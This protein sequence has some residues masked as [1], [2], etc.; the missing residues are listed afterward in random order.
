M[1]LSK[2]L[3]TL[4]L[5]PLTLLTSTATAQR[6]RGV[7]DAYY[8]GIYLLMTESCDDKGI[9]S[10]YGTGEYWCVQ[11]QTQ[12]HFPKYITSD[13]FDSTLQT[14]QRFW[15]VSYFPVQQKHCK[16]R[17]EPACNQRNRQDRQFPDEYNSYQLWGA[18]N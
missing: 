5:T 2:L 6:L 16:L 3:L 1:T 9:C 7:S 15:K 14:N 18:C 12:E 17:Q 4:L 10:Y 11:S 13:Q 8:S